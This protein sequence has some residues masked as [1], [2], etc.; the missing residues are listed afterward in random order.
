[1]DELAGNWTDLGKVLIEGMEELPGTSH[2]ILN[3]IP[4]NTMKRSYACNFLFL[5]ARSVCVEFHCLFVVSVINIYWRSN[6]KEKSI[7]FYVL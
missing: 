2:H 4:K 1:M 6:F 3:A 7:Q 5:A